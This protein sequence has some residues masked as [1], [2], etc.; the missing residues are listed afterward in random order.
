KWTTDDRDRVV[1]DWSR[2][3][4]GQMWDTLDGQD[5]EPGTAQS[6]AWTRTFELLD[7]HHLRVTEYR[8]RLAEKWHPETSSAAATFFARVDQ[9]LESIQAMRDAALANGPA[10]SHIVAS[11]AEA[12]ARLEPVHQQWQADQAKLAAYNPAPAVPGT[13][14]PSPGPPPVSA[15]RQQQLHSQAIAIMSTLAAH[16][17]EAETAM[18]APDEYQP[19]EDLA[20]TRTPDPAPGSGA[21]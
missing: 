9:M 19:Y 10:L 11:L 3:A 1:T 20:Q 12:K 14:S 15:S 21:R 13:P 2:L 16:T 17:V 4:V 8:A 18:R 6:A 7:Y 5:T